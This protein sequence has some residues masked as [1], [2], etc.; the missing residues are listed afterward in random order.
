MATIVAIRRKNVSK[1]RICII[2][3][4]IS[5]PKSSLVGFVLLILA[6]RNRATKI[7]IR[8]QTMSAGSK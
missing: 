8:A 4:S 6:L 7:R 3:I 2:E 5:R 1:R